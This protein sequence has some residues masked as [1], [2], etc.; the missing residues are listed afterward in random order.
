MRQGGRIAPES[1]SY[2][3]ILVFDKGAFGVTTVA[4]EGKDTNKRLF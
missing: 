2:S 1:T 3:S 4:E